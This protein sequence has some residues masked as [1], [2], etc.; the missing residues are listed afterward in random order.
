MTDRMNNSSMD[1][2]AVVICGHGLHCI[3]YQDM[4]RKFDVWINASDHRGHSVSLVNVNC[5][6]S[7]LLDPRVRK[8][9]QQADL[10]G[11]DSMPFL[12]IARL[13][14]NKHSDRLYAPDMM[15]ET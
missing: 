13:L 3:S 4:F 12:H 9:Y 10:L 14:K 1:L 15:L 8:L 2:K 6:V 7:A 5:C 11:I